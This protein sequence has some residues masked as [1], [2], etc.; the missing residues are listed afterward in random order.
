[1]IF[2]R[3]GRTQSNGKKL[4]FV[5]FQKITIFPSRATRQ[6][7][8]DKT[9][10]R[11]F[12]KSQFFKV[13][14]QQGNGDK[15]DLRLFPKNHDFSRSGPPA[16]QRGQNWPSFIFKKIRFFNSGC[17]ITFW[18]LGPRLFFRFLASGCFKIFGPRLYLK[19]WPPAV[20][21]VFLSGC[22]CGFPVQGG[23]NT[24]GGRPPLLDKCLYTT[25]W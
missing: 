1:M 9:Y 22:F 12:Q 3:R 25:M 16:G 11:L 7:N 10:I 8:G 14:A 15:T 2:Q 13:G 20:P 18:P 19:F 21:A 24:V 6:G 4:T 23:R 17:F 5:Y